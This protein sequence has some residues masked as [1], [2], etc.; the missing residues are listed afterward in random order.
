MQWILKPCWA[1]H[2]PA[3]SNSDIPGLSPAE[4]RPSFDQQD[5]SNGTQEQRGTRISSFAQVSSVHLMVNTAP[6]SPSMVKHGETTF[7]Y[8]WLKGHCQ[9]HGGAS[10]DSRSQESQNISEGF[11]GLPWASSPKT[12]HFCPPTCWHEELSVL[13]ACRGGGISLPNHH[14]CN[15][16]VLH[17]PTPGRNVVH[18]RQPNF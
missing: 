1:C 15:S 14:Q 11:H 16:S 12:F 2:L 13:T 7:G 3:T 8:F 6:P 9:V 10:R 4:S 18:H 17:N 5:L